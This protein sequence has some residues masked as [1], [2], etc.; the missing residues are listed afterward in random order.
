MLESIPLEM[1][2]EILT[3]LLVTDV[4]ICVDEDPEPKPYQSVEP[5]MFQDYTSNTH[6]SIPGTNST[7]SLRFSR[8][9]QELNVP[10]LEYP[11]QAQTYAQVRNAR[12]T[13][14]QLETGILYTCKQIYDEGCVLLYQKNTFLFLDSTMFQN[15]GSGK[16]PSS[17]K[18]DIRNM[19]VILAAPSTIYAWGIPLLGPP[20][21]ILEHWSVPYK[22][23]L[24][25][26]VKLRSN[27]L[28]Q[29]TMQFRFW[30]KASSCFAGAKY[31]A[32][33]T[34]DCGE[35]LVRMVQ[36]AGVRSKK[37]VV[38][39]CPEEDVVTALKKVVETGTRDTHSLGNVV[40]GE[41]TKTGETTGT[42]VKDIPSTGASMV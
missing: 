24:K 27:D 32:R 28:H 38:K 41:P 17:R 7:S 8:P 6:P 21:K 26:L 40:E 11:A 22:K 15:N 4:I 9:N 23:L 19:E 42:G 30:N 10:L 36:M 25:D 39:G 1:R 20:A 16:I 29:L 2:L 31:Q 12:S 34:E 18:D 33:I 35:F 13:K 14:Y 3:Y 37:L 5:S